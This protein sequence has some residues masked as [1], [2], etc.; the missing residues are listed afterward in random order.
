[1]Y[2]ELLVRRDGKAMSEDDEQVLMEYSGFRLALEFLLRAK[3]TL[4]KAPF[5]LGLFPASDPAMCEVSQQLENEYDCELDNSMTR[6]GAYYC[7]FQ[8]GS[9]LLELADTKDISNKVDN[10]SL[11]EDDEMFF[12]QYCGYHFIFQF[13][14]E[15][16][17][18]IAHLPFGL[19]LFPEFH[20]TINETSSH[21]KPVDEALVPYGA[22][23][24]IFYLWN[25][26]SNFVVSLSAIDR[27][28]GER[29]TE[30]DESFLL[31][32][33]GFQYC[34]EAW[35]CIYGAVS[36]MTNLLGLWETDP[37]LAEIGERLAHIHSTPVEQDEGFLRYGA[38]LWIVTL[39]Q[40]ILSKIND[41]LL[42]DLSSIHS[43]ES[44]KP[45][46]RSPSGAEINATLGLKFRAAV[47][48][49]NPARKVRVRGL[50]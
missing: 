45:M 12:L 1:M 26:V 9:G 18:Q 41:K 38:Y 28:D 44:T 19:G 50:L 42:G 47:G 8:F 29:M 3:K 36:D 5:G 24:C 46:K 2:L 40:T 16:F 43:S 22:F 25:V 23:V 33:K 11:D 4:T 21:T 17:T 10:R 30:D 20:D 37:E 13:V 6:Y 39:C 27:K 32:Y 15:T 48:L 49:D 34:V 31:E 7:I 35:S 14:L